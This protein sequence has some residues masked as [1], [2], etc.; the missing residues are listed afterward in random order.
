VKSTNFHLTHISKNADLFGVLVLSVRSREFRGGITRDL[1]I[2][3]VPPA[4]I[5]DWRYLTVSLVAGLITFCWFSGD[6]RLRNSV[7]VFDG[8]GLALFAVS[9]TQK[10]LASA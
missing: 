9:G 1:M 7:L 2:G 4:A 10:A 3:A 6:G 5:H 8:A